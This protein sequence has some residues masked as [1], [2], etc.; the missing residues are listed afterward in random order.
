MKLY[1]SWFWLQED[2]GTK[3]PLKSELMKRI[4]YELGVKYRVSNSYRRY[5]GVGLT[6]YAQQ[7]LEDTK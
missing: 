4:M 7:L 2:P 5:E 1:H 6:L 3:K